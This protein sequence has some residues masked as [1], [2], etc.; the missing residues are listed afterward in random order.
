MADDRKIKMNRKKF[1]TDSVL[2]S[3]AVLFMFQSCK[4]YVIAGGA[5]E[6]ANGYSFGTGDI[7]LLNYAYVL[8]QIQAAFYVKLLTSGIITDATE[9]I[10]FSDILKHETAQREFLK[11][12]LGSNAL[13]G[14]QLSFTTVNFTN[15]SS[16]LS[17]AIYFEDLTVQ[18]LNSIASSMQSSAFLTILAQIISVQARHATYI[19]E[20]L[21]AGTFTGANLLDQ[22]SLELN[23]KPAVVLGK[24]TD[25]LKTRLDAS[26]VPAFSGKSIQLPIPILTI[27]AFALRLKL[28]KLNFYQ[29]ATGVQPVAGSTVQLLTQA[30][31][32]LTANQ[33]SSFVLLAQDE[34]NHVNFL[35]SLFNGT[36]VSPVTQS[37]LVIDITANQLFAD[38]ATN[39]QTLLLAAQ[40]LEDTSVRYFKGQLARISAY[41]VLLTNFANIHSVEARHSAYIRLTRSQTQVS[42]KPWIVQNGASAVGIYTGTTAQV[43]TANLYNIYINEDN[44]AQA[45]IEITGING[46]NEIDTDAATGAFDEVLNHDQVRVIISAFII[47]GI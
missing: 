32:Q 46:H 18:G 15:R 12:A 13:T 10:L 5:G 11:T 14:L 29:R 47:I 7:S 2:A 38:I 40:I 36:T 30:Y 27:L 3:G 25:Y 4:K 9:K 43:N 21:Q 1:I 35:T 26:T 42:I 23:I 39:P 16:A 33:Q 19:H 28:L 45:Q 41:P 24:L 8:S 34:Q 37:S 31:S 44:T 20:L 6:G 22:N 17:A